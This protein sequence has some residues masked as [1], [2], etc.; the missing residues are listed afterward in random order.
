MVQAKRY[1]EDAHRREAMT[2][3]LEEVAKASEGKPWSNEL[4][5]AL[6]DR[7]KAEE[8]GQALVRKA[9]P[10]KKLPSDDSAPPRPSF[11]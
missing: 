5:Y 8:N 7:L 11:A 6:K 3:L 4:L 9:A 1:Q 2:R 10:E